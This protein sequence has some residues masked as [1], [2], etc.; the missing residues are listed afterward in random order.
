LFCPIRRRGGGG[1]ENG[2][3]SLAFNL[4]T[5]KRKREGVR[6]PRNTKFE[7][8]ASGPPSK[9]KKKKKKKKKNS[10]GK[11]RKERKQAIQSCTGG[12]IGGREHRSNGPRVPPL[13]FGPRGR[14]QI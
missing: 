5:P 9:K 10:R 2:Q 6:R 12:P 14:S 3:Q 1:K 11:Q 7:K 8:T 13:G 4:Q